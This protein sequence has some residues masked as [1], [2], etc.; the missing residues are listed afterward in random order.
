MLNHI[1]TQLQSIAINASNLIASISPNIFE[2]LSKGYIITP[3]TMAI[4]ATS[5]VANQVAMHVLFNVFFSF[6][7]VYSP[8]LRTDYIVLF[9]VYNPCLPHSHKQLNNWV[10]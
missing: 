7:A 9:K 10:I 8:F 2:L 1:S 4:H 5:Q 6:F 3:L